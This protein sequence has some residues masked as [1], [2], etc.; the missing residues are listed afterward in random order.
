MKSISITFAILL[1]SIS[2]LSQNIIL[3]K[4]SKKG[5][6]VGSKAEIVT[7]QDIA[8]KRFFLSNSLTLKLEDIDLVYNV[9]LNINDT[10][11]LKWQFTIP[12]YNKLVGTDKN[13]YFDDGTNAIKQVSLNIYSNTPELIDYSK[14]LFSDVHDYQPITFTLNN[15]AYVDKIEFS[16]NDIKIQGTSTNEIHSFSYG[17]N[18]DKS[19]SITINI[20]PEQKEDL[21]LMLYYTDKDYQNQKVS[22]P[23]KI[24]Y[25]RKFLFQRFRIVTK[26]NLYLDDFEGNKFPPKISFDFTDIADVRPGDQCTIS[27]ISSDILLKAHGDLE[28]IMPQD[29]KIDIDI[30]EVK[31]SGDYEIRIEGRNNEK[32]TANLYVL[33][34]PSISKFSIANSTNYTIEKKN[35]TGYSLKIEGMDL[36]KM[37]DVNIEL[38]NIENNNSF[39]LEKINSIEEN[40]INSTIYFDGQG[41]EDIPVGKYILRLVRNIKDNDKSL[42][43]AYPISNPVISIIYPKNILSSQL[44]KQ[45]FTLE[46]PDSLY[47]KD[48]YRKRFQSKMG[49]ILTKESPIILKITP[50]PGTAINGP[51]FLQI[52]AKYF[53]VDGN[54]EVLKIT[55]GGN[56]Y[57]SVFDKPIYINLKNEFGIEELKLNEKIS[58]N[59]THSPDV[60]GSNKF[61]PGLNVEYYRGVRF[62]DKLGITMS[63]PPYIAAMKSVRRKTITEDDNGEQLVAYN[64]DKKIEFQ[65]L[66]INA[67]VGFKYRGKTKNYDPSPWAISLY[68]MGLDFAN[69][70]S[71]N[72]QKNDPNNY[73]FVGRGSFNLLLLG[74]YNF[75]NLEN[76]NTRIPVYFGGL[77]IIN[78]I[79]EGSHF[80][81]T[82]GLGVDIK[83]FG[84]N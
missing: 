65:Q 8:L 21:V 72:E 63:I 50:D 74:E 71:T 52:E 59:V 83:L 43:R 60:Y 16:P 23:I 9:T 14:V 33:P 27:P 2:V 28:F 54:Q 36:Q 62:L 15:S 29:K 3:N 18:V 10:N 24:H 42:V 4:S 20:M 49:N 47:T 30:V 82:F 11:T 61:S 84:N 53:K 26:D 51:Q 78:P 37:Q 66:L 80:A 58:V 5:F 48:H 39:P 25:E 41:T 68:L 38:V 55:D 6:L 22:I 77:Y 1:M 34:K 79:D 7:D 40:V 57:I 12:A 13:L 46:Q 45:Y 69:Q 75:I 32:Y 73:N 44:S 76:P 70:S 31:S 56:N 81:F 67:G 19:N 35:H 64:G 17:Y